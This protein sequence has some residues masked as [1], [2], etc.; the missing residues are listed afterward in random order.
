MARTVGIDLGTTNSVISVLEGGDPDVVANAE[1]NRECDP[2]AAEDRRGEDVHK[3]ADL[4]HLE[5]GNETEEDEAHPRQPRQPR[6][7][8]GLGPR[9][10]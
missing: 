6:D 8:V 5:C 3:E 9:L 10:H 2:N 7:S 4:E 1:G